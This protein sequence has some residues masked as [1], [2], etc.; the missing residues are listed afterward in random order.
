MIEKHRN[1]TT[2]ELK[3][4]LGE[5]WKKQLGIDSAPIQLYPKPIINSFEDFDIETKQ[6]Y[7]NI[8][9]FIKSKNLNKTFKVWAT[10]SRVKGT[11]RTIE[12]TDEMKAI[13]GE[14]KV[15]YSDYDYITDA[16]NVP[17]AQQFLDHLGLKVDFAGGEGHKI[18]IEV[19]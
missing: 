17:T 7:T 2:N 16:P 19:E 10:G 13:Y 5:D 3:N 4:L 6:I 15:K 14:N 12:E 8:Y 18:L 1:Y 11:W 9:N